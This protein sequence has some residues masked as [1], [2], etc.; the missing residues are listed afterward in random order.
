MQNIFAAES[1]VCQLISWPFVTTD[2]SWQQWT[3]T[4][5]AYFAAFAFR[6]KGTGRLATF[7][8]ATAAF[9]LI[10]ILAAVFAPL[11]SNEEL[12]GW[13]LFACLFLIPVA[14]VVSLWGLICGDLYRLLRK[15]LG[16]NRV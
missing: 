5:V 1:L 11:P 7:V 13:L 6:A 9:Y 3:P 15:R 16:A 12:F 10:T 14:F 2:C 4:L 8:G